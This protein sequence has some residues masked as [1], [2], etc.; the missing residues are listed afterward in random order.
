MQ[1][2]LT[3]ASVCFLYFYFLN[4]EKCISKLCMQYTLDLVVNR[5]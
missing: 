5:V 2:Y 4:D 1:L 3:P